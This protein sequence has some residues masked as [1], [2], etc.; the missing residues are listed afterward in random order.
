MFIPY[1]SE[2]LSEGR[3][4]SVEVELVGDVLL[5]GEDILLELISSVSREHSLLLFLVSRHHARVELVD[6]VPSLLEQVVDR[7]I[8]RIQ[9]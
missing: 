9:R 7:Y 6:R 1:L 4:F 5:A 2:Y 3:E 8:D